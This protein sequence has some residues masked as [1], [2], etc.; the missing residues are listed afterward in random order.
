MIRAIPRRKTRRGASPM[1]AEA[2]APHT[3][4]SL[5]KDLETLGLRP[6]DAV[7]VHAA[8]RRVGSILGGPD[9]LIR[10]I[11][12]AAGPGGSLMVYTDWAGEY[13]QWSDAPD[14]PNLGIGHIPEQ[15]RDDL[16][17]F[18]PL[19]SRAIRSNGA[20][21]ELV[22]TFPGAQ[23]SASA[24][25]SCAAV[26]AAAVTLTAQHSIDYGYGEASPFAKLVATGGKVLMLGAPLDTMTLL[27]HAEHLADIPGKRRLRYEVPF[28]EE[29]R[30]V[31]RWVEEFNTADPIVD[32]LPGDYFATLV[33]EFLA[34]GTGRE[35]NVG[36]APSV[37]VEARKIV[38]FAVNWLEQRFPKP[39]P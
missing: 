19:S 23:R 37:L 29:G 35:G 3:R 7:L 25:A 22:R 31:W 38:P 34:G 10:A 13:W 27:H 26:G 5:R 16:L 14:D 11:L 12:D 21:A 15:W 30:T 9:A 4:R 32:G 8:L 33:A 24:G 28:L 18:D 39:L 1:P 36:S 2:A 17:P 6:G 20:F